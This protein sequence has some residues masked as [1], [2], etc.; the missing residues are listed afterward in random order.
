MRLPTFAK[1]GSRRVTR[2]NKG[3]WEIL[4]I[5][6]YIGRSLLRLFVLGLQFSFVS[7]LV[8]VTVFHLFGGSS[9]R[10]ATRSE[11]YSTPTVLSSE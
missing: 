9:T 10:T 4:D 11:H 1:Y 6:F 5:D 8:C 2:S 7:A 3:L